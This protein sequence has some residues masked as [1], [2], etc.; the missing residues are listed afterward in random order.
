M[1]SSVHGVRSLGFNWDWFGFEYL[2]ENRTC[3]SMEQLG[4]RL[5]F[6]FRVPY[7]T[8]KEENAAFYYKLMYP[9]YA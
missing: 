6:L 7:L 1:G 5:A 9:S 4:R 8:Y 2:L 3:S